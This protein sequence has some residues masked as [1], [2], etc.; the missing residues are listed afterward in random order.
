MPFTGD[1]AEA[2]IYLENRTADEEAMHAWFKKQ[3]CMPGAPPPDPNPDDDPYG[4]YGADA[5][6]DALDDE[7]PPPPAAVSIVEVQLSRKKDMNGLWQIR[8][9]LNVMSDNAY[10]SDDRWDAFIRQC[11]REAEAR[12]LGV[13]WSWMDGAHPGDRRHH[14]GCELQPASECEVRR[15]REQAAGPPPRRNLGKYGARG[16]AVG[17]KMFREDREKWYARFTGHS[18]AEASLQEQNELC[19]VIARRFRE[20]TDGR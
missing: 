10:Y 6:Y 9:Q 5:Y 1:A 16:D 7:S 15:E 14:G 19:D 3:R 13:H 2:A 11:E 8:V 18:I 17:D 12:H 20:Y 4:G